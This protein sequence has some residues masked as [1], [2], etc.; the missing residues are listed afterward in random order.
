MTAELPEEL[1]NKVQEKLHEECA[2]FLKELEDAR[3]RKLLPSMTPG[4]EQNPE[5]DSEPRSL[6]PTPTPTEMSE[7]AASQ[8]GE[9]APAGEALPAPVPVDSDQDMTGV[10]PPKIPGCNVVDLEPEDD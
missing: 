4:T 10:P 7:E 6:A 8:A 5:A 1:Q 3:S 2:K 9:T